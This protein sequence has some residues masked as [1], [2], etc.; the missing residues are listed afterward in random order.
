MSYIMR[1]T[2]IREHPSCV[3]HF[4]VGETVVQHLS[5]LYMNC[6]GEECNDFKSV[7]CLCILSQ[8]DFNIRLPR[9]I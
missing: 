7:M 8:P 2:Q 9:I 1:R 3:V 6:Y 5:S 4:P